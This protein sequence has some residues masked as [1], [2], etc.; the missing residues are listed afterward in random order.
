M[1]SV[2]VPVAE[3]SWIL[4]VNGERIAAGTASPGQSRELAAGLLLGS[5]FVRSRT[6]LLDLS[7]REGQFATTLEASV[8]DAAFAAAMEER[9]HRERTG[10]GL[11]HFV[12][13]DGD[14]LAIE[15]ALDVPSDDELADR[16]RA[17]FDAC[18]TTHPGGGVHGAAVIAGAGEFGAIDVSRHAAVDKA[19]GAAFLGVE[20]DAPRGLVL[21]A[22]ISGQI[23]LTAA[24]A[25]MSW[26][27]SRSIPTTLAVAIGAAAGVTLVARAGS[28]DV[29][30]FA[31]SARN[32]ET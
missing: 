20:G 11:L 12:A 17:L 28:R 22:R 21:T 25:G 29:H 6:D 23:A 27:A 4:V 3:T 18:S 19:A 16:L 30:T 13:C 15:P 7:I 2:P 8:P 24:R 9:R 14:S 31:P 32:G 1:R 10:C 5:G 26:I